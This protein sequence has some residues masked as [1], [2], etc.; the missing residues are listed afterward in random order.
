MNN[1]ILNNSIQFIYLITAFL[2]ILGMRNM[3]SPKTAKSGVKVAGCGMFFAILVTFFLPSIQGAM[4]YTYML[5]AIALGSFIGWYSGKKVSMISMP[6]MIALY[7]GMGGGAASAIAAMELLRYQ[8][9]SLTIRALAILG[10]IIGTISFSGSIIAFAKLQELIQKVVTLPR[11]HMVNMVMLATS[12]ILGVLILVYPAA[13]WMIVAFFALLLLLG[14]TFT[15]PIGGANMPIVISLFNAMTGLAVGFNGFVLQNSAL[16]I[17]G[18]VVGASGTLLTQLMAK[19][20]NKSVASILFARISDTTTTSSTIST[21]SLKAI[22]NSDAAVMM[23]YSNKVIIVP[24]YGMAVAQ[25]QHK[26]WE[27]AKQ[28]EGRGVTV[29]FAIHPVAGRMPGH[30]NVLLAEAGVPYDKLFDLEEINAEFASTDTVLV[31]GANDVVNPSARNEPDSPI[32]GMPILDVAHAHNILI[33]KRGQG[34]GFSGVEN[35]LFTMDNS[36]MLYGDGQDVVNKLVQ[37]VKSL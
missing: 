32:Y 22:E 14:V 13:I 16:V 19:A 3:A 15:I 8:E 28:L 30:M 34:K 24:G 5:I 26:I 20:M 1:I 6:Q 7:N 33:I 10:A 12:V 18:T 4:N 9:T 23:A 2:L 11:H 31:I 21:G 25:A 29:K 37:S 36:R 17:A 35:S 27:L